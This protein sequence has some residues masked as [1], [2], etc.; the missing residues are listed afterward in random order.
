MGSVDIAMTN[1]GYGGVMLM[2][3]TGDV[4]LL[5]DTPNNP[6][7]TLQRIYRLILTNATLRDDE[8]NPIAPADDLFNPDWGASLRERVGE[9]YSNT[10]AQQIVNSVTKALAQD[11]GITQSPAPVVT[12]T[13]DVGAALIDVICYTK[14]GQKLTVPTATL[15]L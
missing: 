5:V 3:A 2:T 9:M 12:V 15:K 8:G 13:Q 10:L 1:N 4:Q 7:A 11:G 6:A 14:D